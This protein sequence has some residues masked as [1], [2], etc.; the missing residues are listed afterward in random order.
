[1]HLQTQV[2]LAAN[3]NGGVFPDDITN[4]M[5]RAWF[6]KVDAHPFA[7]ATTPLGVEVDASGD[8]DLKHPA[9]KI[10]NGA[11]PG[12]WYNPANGIVRSRVKDLGSDELN[13]DL[14][15][16]INITSIGGLQDVN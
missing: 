12:W 8:I 5:I 4:D 16:T 1:K 13:V 3:R 11:L 14:Y 9:D 6:G 7:I 15:R 10:I 2:L